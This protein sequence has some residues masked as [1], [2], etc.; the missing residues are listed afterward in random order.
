MKS[1]SIVGLC[2]CLV[3]SLSAL[4]VFA[5]GPLDP[6]FAN[7]YSIYAYPIGPRSAYAQAI[8][9][10]SHGRLVTAGYVDPSDIGTTGFLTRHE[11]SPAGWLDPNFDS[12]GLIPAVFD[13]ETNW[14]TGVAV[15]HLGHIVAAGY[16]EATKTCGSDPN[17]YVTFYAI[18]R[19]H[20]DDG[21]VD[22]SLDTSFAAIGSTPG[23]AL[24]VVGDCYST[25]SAKAIAIDAKD[26][27]TVVGGATDAGTDVV[28]LARWTSDG[29]L[30]T[31]FGTNG[32]VTTRTPFKAAT[33]KAVTIDSA[34]KIWVAAEGKQ[35]VGKIAI[36]LRYNVDGSLD[37]SFGVGG[38]ATIG[39]SVNGHVCCIA[40]DNENRAL[41]AGDADNAGGPNRIMVAR[42]NSDGRLDA[43]FGTGGI[44][45]PQVSA[46]YSY[47]YGLALD[48]RGRPMVV[49][50][51]ADSDLGSISLIHYNLD[52]TLNTT[53][54]FG[55]IFT[56][57]LGE[58]S[59]VGAALQI[60]PLGRPTVAG[61]G[62]DRDG[63]FPVLVRYD[64]LY[65]EGFD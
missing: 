35:P 37:S 10:D 59:S 57:T 32:V 63:A 22:G 2:A 49:G 38:M 54:G 19:F 62:Y 40:L 21:F 42:F 12:D 25:R 3:F 39:I 9:S 58:S 14:L 15:D 33:G 24:A 55:G 1:R 26:N 41:I 23:H 5:D 65:S 31:G 20:N 56:T 51:T 4:P 18:A 60:D 34:G 11:L 29:N 36:V 47:S 28:G 43:A 8:T 61:Y 13:G 50:D 45:K 30:D 48:S 16:V 52:G 6:Q 64:E 53:A 17:H 46:S 44:A 27:I 7:G